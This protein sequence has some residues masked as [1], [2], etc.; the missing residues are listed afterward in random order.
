MVEIIVPE[1]RLVGP[2]NPHAGDHRGM[3]S[4]VRQDQAIRQQPADRA[5]CRLISDIAGR[6]GERGLLPMQVGELR[7]ECNDSMAI[8]RDVS[9]APSAGAN[10]ARGLDH[11]VDHKGMPP[12]PKIIVAA[13]Y[14]D[15]AAVIAIAPACIGRPGGVPLQIGEDAIATLSTNVVEISMKVMAQCHRIYPSGG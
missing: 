7:L 13:P 15:F 4:L 2:A 9:R 3:V 12:H 11:G 5:K 14:D 8:A 10:A 1:N 6:E